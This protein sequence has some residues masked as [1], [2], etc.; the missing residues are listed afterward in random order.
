MRGL[1]KAKGKN[2]PDR[3]DRLDRFAAALRREGAPNRAEERFLLR[4][5]N[6]PCADGFMEWAGLKGKGL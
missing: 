4:D 3:Q 1:R 5:G 2:K 6:V